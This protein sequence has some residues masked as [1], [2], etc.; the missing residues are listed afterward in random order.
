MDP[1]PGIDGLII[2]VTDGHQRVEA[3]DGSYISLEG[4]S[5]KVGSICC[6]AVLFC[7]FV[8]LFC[9]AKCTKSRFHY[10]ICAG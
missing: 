9:C 8:V 4:D 7:C 1:Q 10:E 6:F 3:K 2:S 5:V